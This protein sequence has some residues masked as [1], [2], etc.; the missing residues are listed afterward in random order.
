M[1]STSRRKRTTTQEAGD[2]KVV[3]WR[4]A[5]VSG[6]EGKSESTLG[7]AHGTTVIY[8]CGVLAK[9]MKRVTLRSYGNTDS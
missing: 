7:G 6:H 9:L 4:L 8:D 2:A 1:K 5:S 3:L